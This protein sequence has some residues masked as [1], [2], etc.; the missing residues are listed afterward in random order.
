MNNIFYDKAV[1]ILHNKKL[2][3]GHKHT[4]FHRFRT[5]HNSLLYSC[6]PI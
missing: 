1:Y 4:G 5:L 2:L 6:I 3:L